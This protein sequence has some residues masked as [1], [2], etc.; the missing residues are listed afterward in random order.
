MQV[1]LK[2]EF[3]SDF[4]TISIWEKLVNIP[5]LLIFKYF[6]SSHHLIAVRLTILP[7]NVLLDAFVRE[8]ISEDSVAN[9]QFSETTPLA[10]AD[11][12]SFCVFQ[13]SRAHDFCQG[14]HVR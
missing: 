2:L 4:S 11:F 8:C 10:E 5:A 9:L 3:Y 7:V 14:I 1:Q 13:L 6:S 12:T